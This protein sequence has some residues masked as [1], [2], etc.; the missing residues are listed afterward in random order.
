MRKTHR[1]IENGTHFMILNQNCV[2]VEI[3]DETLDKSN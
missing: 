1:R 2:I 3:I